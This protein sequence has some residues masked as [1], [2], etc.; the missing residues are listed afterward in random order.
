MTSG[1]TKRTARHHA[2]SGPYADKRHNLT[3][4]VGSMK[5]VTRSNV[6]AI[7]PLVRTPHVAQL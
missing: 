3:T 1:P 4:R 2:E 6:K 7:C 5:L